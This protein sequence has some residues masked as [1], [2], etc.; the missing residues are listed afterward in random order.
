MRVLGVFLLAAC[1]VGQDDTDPIIIETG[2]LNEERIGVTYQEGTSIHGDAVQMVVF[3]VSGSTNNF[4]EVEIVNPDVDALIRAD[5]SDAGSFTAPIAAASDHGLTIRRLDSDV[6][7]TLTVQQ[8]DAFPE[9]DASSVSFPHDNSVL[10]LEFAFVEAPPQ[11]WNF[12]AVNQTHHAVSDAFVPISD[13]Q[14]YGRIHATPGDDLFIYAMKG[15][16]VA[17]E[18]I[19]RIAP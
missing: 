11:D 1:T 5:V 12:Y 2:W 17:T 14:I 16:A 4:G 3:G 19:H 9:V 15:D 8:L 13:T 10:A 18:S 6:L 7:L